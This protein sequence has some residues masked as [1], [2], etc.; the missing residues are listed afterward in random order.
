M[1][2]ARCR[3]RKRGPIGRGQHSLPRFRPSIVD[4]VIRFLIAL[5]VGV[6]AGAA[7]AALRASRSRRKEHVLE[8]FD[9]RR[10]ELEQQFRALAA[11]SGKPR[12]LRW[13]ECQFHDG[14][15]FARDRGTDELV[16]LL[17][18]TIRFE[19]VEGGGMEEV[20]AVDNLRCATAVFMHN[21]YE[22]TTVGRA[23]FNLEPPEVL[24]HYADNLEPLPTDDSLVPDRSPGV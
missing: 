18:V 9:A 23:V 5:V 24:T 7:W 12:G 16:A 13:K 17:G 22:W 6:L 3:Q 14:A 10:A 2:A 20:E 1:L 8:D 4:S 21:G 11:A 19:A 15:H